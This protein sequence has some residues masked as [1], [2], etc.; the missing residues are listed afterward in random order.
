MVVVPV[1]PLGELVL[2]DEVVPGATVVGVHGAV[3]VLVEPAGALGPAV[4]VLGVVPLGVVAVPLVVPAV[5]AL[6]QGA[7]VRVPLVPVVPTVPFTPVVPLIP[8]APVGPMLPGV[9][10]APL[11]P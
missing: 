7:I 3:L 11:V 4:A 8:F 2:G 9:C 1:V 6:A 10:C 5:P